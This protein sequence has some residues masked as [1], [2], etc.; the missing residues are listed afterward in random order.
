MWPNRWTHTT[1]KVWRPLMMLHSIGQH[2]FLK[3]HMPCHISEVL[4]WCYVSLV[5]VACMKC[6]RIVLRSL[7]LANVNVT[8]SILIENEL[9]VHTLDNVA[10][11]Y[12]MSLERS[13]Q[14]KLDT[15]KPWE[16]VHVLGRLRL[17]N[18]FI[19]KQTLPSWC[20]HMKLLCADLG[21]CCLL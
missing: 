5:D 21:W 16:M 3:A 11:H 19:L 10:C 17:V 4:S 18:A 12:L 9:F 6:K 15:W 20:T 13:S 8:Q 2:R 7:T 14:T 1:N